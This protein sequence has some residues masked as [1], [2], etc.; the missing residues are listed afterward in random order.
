MG[1]ETSLVTVC[2]EA[3]A[4]VRSAV[5]GC[6][7]LGCLVLDTTVLGCADAPADPPV[8]PPVS[9]S[10]DSV[11]VDAAT[12]E[13]SRITR[14]ALVVDPAA[15]RYADCARISVSTPTPRPAPE[16]IALVAAAL[17]SSGF[18]LATRPEGLVLSHDTRTHPPSCAPEGRPADRRDAGP[19]R[20]RSVSD[21]EWELLRT[22]GDSEISPNDLMRQARV[23]PYEVD[24]VPAGLRLYGV[25]RASFFGQLGFENGDTILDVNGHA[26]ANPEAAL[27]AYAVLRDA[28]RYEVHL[29]RHGDARTHVI[30]VVDHFTS[31]TPAAPSDASE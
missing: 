27:E 17:G 13:L 5:Q 29:E 30:R 31:D 26:L 24:G 20:V 14:L 12:Q 8:P 10:L 18:T 9:L 4:S 19:S 2:A 23:I 1:M 3:R 7:V 21:T 16:V 25:R 28:D 15:E 6:M 22:P 11:S